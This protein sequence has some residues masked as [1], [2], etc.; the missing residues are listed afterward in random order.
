MKVLKTLV[1]CISVLLLSCTDSDIVDGIYSGKIYIN[2]D[3]LDASV[4]IAQ[5][6]SSQIKL[7]T[8]YYSG[9]TFVDFANLKKNNAEAYTFEMPD[10]LDTAGAYVLYGYYYEG[11]INFT[12]YGNNYRFE[13]NR[14]E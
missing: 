2:N 14:N 6:N 10:V 8:N 13:G 11:Y 7:E 4:T 1:V 12:S 3:T 5:M 9:I